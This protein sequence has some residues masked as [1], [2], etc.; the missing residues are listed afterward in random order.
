MVAMAIMVTS[1]RDSL[2]A[3]TQRIL[4]ADLYVR[5][6]YTSQSSHFTEAAVAALRDIPGIAKIQVS[7]FAQADLA[8]QRGP[9]TLIARDLDVANA[10]QALWIEQRADTPLPSGAVPVWISEAAA[11]LFALRSGETVD[12]VIAG[13][14]VA[15]V[16]RGIWRDYEH[17]SGAIVMERQTYV[18]LSGDATVNTIWFWLAPGVSEPAVQKQIRD[19]LPTDSEYDMRTPRELRQLSL[20]AFDRTFAVTYALELIAILIGLFG[21]SAGTSAQV[22]ARRREFGVLRHIGLTRAQIAA[23]LA[24]EGAGL[25]TLGVLAGLITGGAVSLILIYVVNRQSFHWSMELFVPGGLLIGLS[26]ALIA[27]AAGIAVFSGRQAMRG[28]VVKAVKEDW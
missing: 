21:I 16:V 13:K 25:G 9:V 7:R 8:G 20:Q 18:R 12:L 26:L 6:G 15:A 19:R 3:W 24:I 1:F 10:D 23:T 11:D 14:P 28:D 4:P 27:S 17:Q 22:L 5:A 2:D